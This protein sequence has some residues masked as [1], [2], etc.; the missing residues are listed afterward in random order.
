MSTLRS[1]NPMACRI[2]FNRVANNIGTT[3]YKAMMGDV[4]NESL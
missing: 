3:P 4:M 2:I 1:K